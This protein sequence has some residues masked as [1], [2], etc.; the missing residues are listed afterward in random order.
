VIDLSSDAFLL[1]FFHFL[2]T[3]SLLAYGLLFQKGSR[4][5][6]YLLVAWSFTLAQSVLMFFMDANL[7]PSAQLQYLLEGLGI[8]SFA[9]FL[10]AYSALENHRFSLHQLLLLLAVVMFLFLASVFTLPLWLVHLLVGISY[11]LLLGNKVYSYAQYFPYRSKAEHALLALTVLAMVAQFHGYM[12]SLPSNIR[13]LFI[14]LVTGLYIALTIRIFN[15]RTNHAMGASLIKERDKV[16]LTIKIN[17]DQSL[18]IKPQK[19]QFLEYAQI[20]QNQ[21]DLIQEYLQRHPEGGGLLV[22]KLPTKTAFIIREYTMPP[23][24]QVII[25]HEAQTGFLQDTGT[26]HIMRRI[27][28]YFPGQVFL[29]SGTGVIYEIYHVKHKTFHPLPSVG[30]SLWDWF[31]GDGLESNNLLT[32]SHRKTRVTGQPEGQ[33][34][35]VEV[36]PTGMGKGHYNYLVLVAPENSAHREEWYKPVSNIQQRLNWRSHPTLF[37]NNEG[38]VEAVNKPFESYFPLKLPLQKDQPLHPRLLFSKDFWQ[39][40][41]HHFKQLILGQTPEEYEVSLLRADSG[42]EGLFHVLAETMPPAL[43]MEGFLITYIPLPAIQKEMEKLKAQN[44]DLPGRE[45]KNTELIELLDQNSRIP[46]NSVFGMMELLE[47][48]PLDQEQQGYLHMLQT[49]MKDFLSINNDI[50][51]QDPQAILRSSPPE[52]NDLGEIF[53]KIRRML[54]PFL[55]LHHNAISW[56]KE[57]PPLESSPILLQSFLFLLVQHLMSL[58]ENQRLRVAHR[59]TKGTYTLLFSLSHPEGLNTTALD[60]KALG[61]YLNPLGASLSVNQGQEEL[62]LEVRFSLHSGVPAD[63]NKGKDTTLKPLKT[64]LIIE[65]D[66]INRLYF[67]AILGKYPLEVLEA[68]GGMEALIL[69]KQQQPDL[70]LLDL[71]MPDMD[72]YETFKAI[73]EKGLSCPIFAITAF[74]TPE[75]QEKTATLGFSEFLTKPL[76]EKVLMD[77]I[78]EYFQVEGRD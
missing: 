49:S 62:H 23:S 50:I 48:T 27:F 3:L 45:P 2:L 78:R 44:E 65:D 63:D 67:K 75:A 64:V 51:Q 77:A 52:T 21:A 19:V 69:L 15:L 38:L 14:Y 54:I 26:T 57:F 10:W 74:A 24:F 5:F 41:K 7:L 73:R 53:A 20:M 47:E 72:G 39:S 6:R 16:Q 66:Q 31:E 71:G 22:P 56:T 46:L 9:F 76:R 61:P 33:E 30:E 28:E 55:S 8:W 13:A 36:L 4:P 42:E 17:T 37:L 1:A 68:G 59:G 25:R 18:E 35:R 60:L 58:Q 11:A 70:I 12:P 34:V 32:L 43:N 40:Q 29:C